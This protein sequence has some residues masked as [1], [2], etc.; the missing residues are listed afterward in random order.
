[1]SAADGNQPDFADA[2][3]LAP[4]WF[5]AALLQHEPLPRKTMQAM[6]AFHAEMQRISALTQ[7][8]L[9]GEI[10]Y[11]WWMD[12]LNGERAGE[13]RAHPLA[14]HVI[15]ICDQ[16]DIPSS[17]LATKPEAH[18]FE[19]YDDPM[20]NTAMF[21]GWCGNVF[22]PLYQLPALS[23]GAKAGAQLAEASGHAGVISGLAH[24]A[25]HLDAIARRNHLH[26]PDEWLSSP[27]LWGDLGP[28]TDQQVLGELSQLAN[29][30]MA[31]A[32]KALAELPG[33]VRRAFL[34]LA[35]E[36][37]SLKD[38]ERRILVDVESGKK[39]SV[40]APDLTERNLALM[41]LLWRSRKQ[42]RFG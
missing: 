10:R 27:Q 40:I 39:S 31:S 29:Q 2:R 6:A 32:E 23:A 3:R 11:Q 42:E 22:S 25:R 5:Y 33:N 9:A 15:D 38:A 4:A 18:I 19:L 30:H 34:P 8:P 12:V 41:W 26:V 16:L 37:R 17:S 24:V 35:V 21:E 20:E 36:E 14:R 1:M 28:K 7:E 13:A